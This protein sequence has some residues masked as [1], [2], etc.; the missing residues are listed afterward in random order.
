MQ[1]DSAYTRDP[2]TNSRGPDLFLGLGRVLEEC[3]DMEDRIVVSAVCVFPQ[4]SD[5]Q[6]SMGSV[7]T[8]RLG[9][10]GLK[11]LF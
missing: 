2:D 9:T 3:T 11:A 6:P 5:L 7:A 4:I 10:A 1:S 8:H